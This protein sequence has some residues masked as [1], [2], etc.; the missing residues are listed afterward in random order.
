MSIYD[1]PPGTGSTEASGASGQQAEPRTT[2]S[3]EN[4]PASQPEEGLVRLK[5][6]LDE[7]G[8]GRLRFLEGKETVKL[9]ALNQ[10]G[11]NAL[12]EQ[13]LMRKPHS[14][15]VGALHDWVELDGELFK[16]KADPG[17]AAALEEVI[18]ERYVAPEKP[19]A[20][21]NISVFPNP[22]SPTGFDLQFPAKPHGFAENCRRHLN[23][24]TVELL[25]D[26]DKCSVLRKGTMATLAPPLLVFK[27]RQPDGSESHL[28]PGPANTVE[29]HGEHGEQKVIDLSQPVDLLHLS[30]GQ[31]TDVL[32]HPA[33][34][35]RAALAEAAASQGEGGDWDEHRAAA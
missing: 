2:Q 16:F 34:N 11:F 1:K 21:H 13:D 20:V 29:T 5:I 6:E 15:K 18:N 24:E 25:Q 35:R 26:P 23:E 33:I 28:E 30:A 9:V 4:K 10:Q 32:N 14:L 7:A 27:R 3:A 12:I 22:A 8:K 31:L 17:R 19:G